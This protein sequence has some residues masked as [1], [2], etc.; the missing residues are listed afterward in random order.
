MDVI[1]I[2]S[3][4]TKMVAHRGLSG[5]E[6]ENTCP[7]F[8]AAGNRSYY[9]IE[10]DVHVT[11]DGKFVIIHDRT[12]KRVSDGKFDID[13]EDNDYSVLESV[14]LPDKDGSFNRQD[15]RIPLLEDYIKICKKYEKVCV[16]ELKGVFGFENAKRLVEAIKDLGYI[17]KVTFISFAWENCIDIRKLLPENDVQWLTEDEVDNEMIE[18][19]VQN[20]LNLDIYYPRLTKE[21][22]AELHENGIKVNCWTC[23]TKEEGEK[24][25]EM[26]VDYITS[27]ILE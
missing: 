2:D 15:I 21:N 20:N 26:G 27:N 22:V 7:A 9:G 13:V 5:L 11:K 12:T 25:V 10:T 8:V 4:E 3:K 14:V 18:K 1:R 24:L 23:D 16:L 17:E 19:L 6:R